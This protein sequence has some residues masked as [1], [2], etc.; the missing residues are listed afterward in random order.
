MILRSNL[1]RSRSRLLRVNQLLN[2]F[3][4]GGDADFFARGDSR[5]SRDL[6]SSLPPFVKKGQFFNHLSD[7]RSDVAASANGWFTGF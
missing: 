5:F 3:L 7:P 1:V 2:C 4:V 6:L